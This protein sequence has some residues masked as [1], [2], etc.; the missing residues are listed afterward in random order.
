MHS[1]SGFVRYVG[2]FQR[3]RLRARGSISRGLCASVY[4]DACRWSAD[5]FDQVDQRGFKVLAYCNEHDS[6]DEQHQWREVCQRH[7]AVPRACTDT[8]PGEILVQP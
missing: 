2:D 3:Q 8:W 7:A 4:M 1:V 5:S 6:V